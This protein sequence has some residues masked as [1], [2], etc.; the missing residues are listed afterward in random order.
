MF[1]K[2]LNT[3]FFK[4]V[5]GGACQTSDVESVIAG[6]AGKVHGVEQV[7]FAVHSEYMDL[8]VGGLYRKDSKHQQQ[9]E[10]FIYFQ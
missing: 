10:G 8:A 1:K 5:I 6:Y 7:T 4:A 9:E 2:T 3:L